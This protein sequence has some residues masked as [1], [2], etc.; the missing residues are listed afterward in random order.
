MSQDYVSGIV[1]D[2]YSRRTNNGEMWNVVV[3]GQDVGWGKF[4]PKFGVGSEVEFDIRWNG[5]YAN[6]D[7]DTLNVINKVGEGPRSNNGGGG[8]Q[9]NQGGGGRQGGNGGGGYGGRS[10][11]GSN[12]G[13]RNGGGGGGYGG[14]RQDRQQQQQAPRQQTRAPQGG[15]GKDDYWRRKEER[16][17]EVQRAIQYQSSRNAAIA[18]FDVLLKAEAVKLPAK[19]AD[20]YDAALAL[21]EELTDHFN[22]QVDGLGNPGGQGSG[23]QQGR[24]DEPD[25]LPDDDLPP[26]NEQDN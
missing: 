6:A 21:I 20:K 18:A 3:N 17:V 7:W 11:G 10:N 5:N 9:R 19:Q 22:H 23:R 25:Q 12:G 16:D 2:I 1:D 8:G 26:Y 13:S 24:N 4:P 14:Q 15:D